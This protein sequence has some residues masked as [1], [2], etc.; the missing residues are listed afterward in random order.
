MDGFRQC[1]EERILQSTPTN[2][3]PASAPAMTA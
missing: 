2:F 3:S 1:W